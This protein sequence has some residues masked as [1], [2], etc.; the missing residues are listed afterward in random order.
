MW[1]RTLGPRGSLVRCRTK[2]LKRP[3]KVTCYRLPV[4]IQK[5]WKSVSYRVSQWDSWRPVG[6]T[7]KG[8]NRRLLDAVALKALPHANGSIRRWISN[9]ESLTESR[10]TVPIP[11]RQEVSIEPNRKTKRKPKRR[12]FKSVYPQTIHVV[13][14]PPVNSSS[15]PLTVPF[16][17]NLIA[18]NSQFIVVMIKWIALLLVA[19]ARRL[20]NS[21]FSF[22]SESN[23]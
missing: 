18:V 12:T 2:T 9:S 17:D 7:D 10:A 11:S 19:Y 14:S 4:A 21:K 6:W 15:P 13:C 8:N 20:W 16:H 3:Y 22:R 5:H 23:V 1:S